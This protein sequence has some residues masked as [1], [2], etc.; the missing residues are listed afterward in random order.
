MRYRSGKAK[1]EQIREMSM[2]VGY[3]D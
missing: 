1:K 3:P 2:R